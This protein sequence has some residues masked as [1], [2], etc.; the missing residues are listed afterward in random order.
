VQEEVSYGPAGV[1]GLNFGWRVMEGTDCNGLGA[2]PVGTPP[3]ND[4]AYTPPVH[5]YAH[6][7]AGVCA[8]SGGYV[9]RGCAIPD[10]QGT[11]FFADT[12]S[13]QIWSF[14]WDGTTKTDF[15]DRTVELDPPVGGNIDFIVSFGEDSHGELYIVELNGQIWK[16]VADGAVAGADCDLN[17]QIDSC[18]IASGYVTD[19]DSNTVP[20][21]CDPLSE[22]RNVMPFGTSVN[23]T[24]NAGASHAG[25]F[26]WLLGSATGTSPGFPVS[27]LTMP[28]TFDPYTAF[29]LKHPLDPI[30]TTLVGFL[31]VDGRG[32]AAFN[33]PPGLDPDLAGITLFHAYA[34]SANQ[35]TVNFVSNAVPVTSAL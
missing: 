17:A 33:C 32:S 28:L 10:L 18:E 5:T 27:G 15:T 34:L 21:V 9:Y 12:C 30:F 26:Y 7:G 13:N 4:P 16:I 31:D 22:D 3:C 6:P 14:R 19:F 24:L 8:V 2:C 1:G 20:D 11:Y 23:F 35:M 25:E 29:T